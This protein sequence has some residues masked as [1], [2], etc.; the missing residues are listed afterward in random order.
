LRAR[1]W[2]VKKASHLLMDTLKWRRE[3]K[4]D[5]ICWKDIAFEA[6]SGK[7]FK[8][9]EDILGRPCIYMTP[10]RENSTNYEKNIKLLV[11]TIE[12]AIAS[13]KDGVEQMVWI[14]DFEGYSSKNA[15]P[16]S[17]VK[18]IIHILSNY[19]PERLGS[20]II[21]NP[22]KIFKMLYAAAKPLIPTATRNKV[23]WISDKRNQVET[24]SKLFNMNQME[25]RFGGSS[26]FEFDIERFWQHE[27]KSC[28]T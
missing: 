18:E 27:K 19:Y 23:I 2:N 6:S 9:G 20:A 5:E 24:L 14:A 21:I 15:F 10:A 3:Y 25:K 1:D 4:P 16:L 13:M 8:R 26:D 28:L 17:V 12:Q 7:I 22:P 11:Y